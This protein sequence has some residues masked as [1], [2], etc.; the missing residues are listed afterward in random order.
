MEAP[1]AKVLEKSIVVHHG[2]SSLAWGMHYSLFDLEFTALLKHANR[3]SRNNSLTA[4][5][6]PLFFP[7]GIAN[8]WQITKENKFYLQTSSQL[9]EG[10]VQQCISV[11]T[12][13][14]YVH[15][16][17]IKSHHVPWGFWCFSSYQFQ[18]VSHAFV[19]APDLKHIFHTCF[20][21]TLVLKHQQDE[22]P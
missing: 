14:K 9:S 16:Y 20:T 11:L 3:K 6:R 15:C 12:S 13:Q 21:H 1:W 10:K 8:M 18:K 5:Q 19:K 17:R 7:L 22:S 2:S 4:K